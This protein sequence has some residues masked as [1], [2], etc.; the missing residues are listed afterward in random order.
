MDKARV[1]FQNSIINSNL[2][3]KLQRSVSNKSLHVYCLISTRDQL[4]QRS[5]G[6]TV[7]VSDNN[8]YPR[9]SFLL[10]SGCIIVDFVQITRRGLPGSTWA[11]LRRTCNRLGCT[12]LVQ[13]CFCWGSNLR[14]RALWLVE[15]SLVPLSPNRPHR[16]CE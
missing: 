4:W 2:P 13:S 5:N 9:F 10:E 12:E 3:C 8:S 11:A 15:S 14:Q 1:S 16:H 6:C 7:W